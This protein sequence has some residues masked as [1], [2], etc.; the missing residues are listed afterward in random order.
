MIGFSGIHYTILNVF[1]QDIEVEGY[2]FPADY[3]V[4]FMTYSAQRDPDVF[5]NPDEFIPERWL[6][7]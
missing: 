5:K 6:N 3:A 2:K 7:R 1:F 4:V